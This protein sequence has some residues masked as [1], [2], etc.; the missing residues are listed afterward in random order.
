MSS[1]EYREAHRE[2]LNAKQKARYWKRRSELL[3]YR[4][5]YHASPDGRRKD[6]NSRIQRLYAVDA[7]WYDRT[8]AE[9]QGLCAICKKPCPSG[10]RLAVDHVHDETQRVRGLLCCKCNRGIGNFNDTPEF[11]DAAAAYLRKHQIP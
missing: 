10:R 2:E 8:L 9:Q 7:D 6:M 4:R 1:K 11:L 5:A 3:T